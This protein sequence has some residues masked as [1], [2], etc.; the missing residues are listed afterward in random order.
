V[1]TASVGLFSTSVDP[2]DEGV[3]RSARE[4]Q[5][6][7]PVRVYHAVHHDTVQP[8]PEFRDRQDRPRLAAVVSFIAKCR[9]RITTRTYVVP[10]C[11]KP[12]VCESSGLIKLVSTD[13][14]AKVST[15]DARGAHPAVPLRKHASSK[16]LVNIRSCPQSRNDHA[17]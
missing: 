16:L 13:Q 15:T 1:L 3:H 5:V 2:H 6:C 11:N 4:L 9:F 12:H 14:L 7:G 8:L 10:K 17:V